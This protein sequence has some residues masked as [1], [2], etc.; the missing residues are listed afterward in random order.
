MRQGLIVIRTARRVSLWLAAPLVLA[1]VGSP[2]FAADDSS[3]QR[4]LAGLRERALF[5]LAD[6]YCA[7]KL[8]D[9]ALGEGRR[10][11]LVIEL[12][13]TLADWAVSSPPAE[14]PALWLR[15]QRVTDEF[16]QQHPE[17]PR[18]PLVRFQGALAVLARGELARQ[19]SELVADNQALVEEARTQLREAIRQLEAICDDVGE[20]LRLARGTV[21]RPAAE[22]LTEHQLASL[23]KSVQYQLA[24]AFRNQGQSYPPDSADRANSLTRALAL[25]DPLAKLD[26]E[27][28]LAFES[29]LDE[30]VCWRLL[31]DYAMA[32]R[33][34]DALD[35]A[36]P[37]AAVALAARAERI[38]LALATGELKQ[39]IAL[40][41]AGRTLDGA[42]SPELDFA[43]LQTYL[44]AWR[45][46]DRSGDRQSSGDWQSKATETVRLIEQK[47]G[48][49]WTRRAEMLLAGYVR[50]SP[51][52]GGLEMR[53]R[54]A[55]SSFRSGRL[56][57]ALADYDAACAMAQRQGLSSRAFELGYTAAAIE[58]QRQHHAEAMARF[59]ALSLTDPRQAKAAD[60]HLLA[61]YHA[62]QLASVQSAESSDAIGPYVEL[63]RE[64]LA[65]W[66]EGPTA[67]Q[68][69][70][71]LGRLCE[72][73]QDWPGA[74][75]AYRTVSP[76]F[77]RFAEVVEG[78]AR[79]WRA[80]LDQKRAAGEPVDAAV[81]D[82]AGWFESIVF[83]PS[84]QV[85]TTW[86]PAARA[87]ALEAARLWLDYTASGYGRAEQL[88]S[89]ALAPEQI[90]DAPPEW[91]SAA[92]AM[93]VY[94]L[95]GQGRRDEAAAVLQQVS[96]GPPGQ[97]LGVLQGLL[98]VVAAARP[99]A[100]PEWAEIALRAAK[101]MDARRGELDPGQRQTADRLKA[102]ALAV[103]GRTEEALAAYQWL[104]KI[105]SHDGDVQE[106]YAQL[107][108]SR[109]D[110]PS[111][112]TALAKW[113]EIDSGS[114]PA[115][116]RWF[117][118]KYE[119]A[120]LHLRLGD[121]AQAVK[122]INLLQLLHPELG[123]PA[124]KAR[125]L[126]LLEQARR[127]P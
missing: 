48:P 70:W 102:Q 41:A 11:D 61:I 45:A 85:P 53:V 74:I 122:I 73:Q 25:L 10:A 60:A 49:Y 59:R 92:R 63:L 30:V 38:R 24:R 27:H 50:N 2:A 107:L 76:Q 104:A 94:S 9:S 16:V 84:R 112:E 56:D 33:K 42:T 17:N 119:V 37:P 14:R 13:L 88:L 103:A 77:G 109:Q 6:A 22:N 20:R 72:H 67:D 124:M 46:A 89:T 29:R 83:G 113:R 95:A 52:G 99:D 82:A 117:R 111:L 98:R 65:H 34:L 18:L 81:A 36:K 121:R 54:A 69:R 51:G 1:T 23:E 66:P 62:E 116:D 108:S 35:A 71:R 43:W 58:H 28:P 3:D 8:G 78:A 90:A 64:H 120:S 115:S 75:A 101:L 100:K 118:A 47:D 40:V 21:G 105:Y 12:S 32:A 86:T 114:R 91:T 68:V 125:F 106:A 57:D 79:C 19:E 80:W 97:L 7:A 96:T 110:R 31:A 26:A 93:L 126:E 127:G 44:E 55:E 15:A 87:A 39:A 123:G 5:E 4:F